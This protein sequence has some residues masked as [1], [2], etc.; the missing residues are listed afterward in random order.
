MFR[1]KSIRRRILSVLM[2]IYLVSLVVTVGAGW[3]V[4]KA[5]A[6]KVAEEKTDLFLATM[7]ASRRY[8]VEHLRPRTKE[9][10]PGTYFPEGSV[11]ILMLSQIGRMLQEDHPEYVYRIASDNALNPANRADREE[12]RIIDQFA[13]QGDK[14]WDGFV[15]RGGETYYTVATAMRAKPGCMRCH[16]IPKAAPKELVAEYGVD[17]GFGYKNGEVVGATF[18]YV[19]ISVALDEARRKLAIFAAAFSLFFLLVL[20]VVDRVLVASVV[21]PIEGFVEAAEAVSTGDLSREFK[22]DSV[23]EMHTLA[24]A[25]T[26]MK[27]SIEKSLSMLRRRH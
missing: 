9:L 17:G 7:N 18:A 23:D 3:V 10:L 13:K 19:P 14:R 4:L 11:G 22:V 2:I 25:F 12:L 6:V 27:V 5:E 8:M 16:S 21:R 24:D 15:E 20:L 1:F 26:R